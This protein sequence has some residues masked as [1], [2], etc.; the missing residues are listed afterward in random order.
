ME[1]KAVGFH[2][3]YRC[4][5]YITRHQVRRKLDT[6]EVSINQAGSQTCQ[7]CLCNSWHSFY[8]YMTVSQNCRQHQIHRLFLPDN[9]GSNPVFQ[10][11]YLLGKES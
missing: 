2:V 9:D 10:L 8:Q 5:Q 3:E 11:L 4:A 7:Q 1:I 6:A